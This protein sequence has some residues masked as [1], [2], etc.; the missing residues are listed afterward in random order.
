MRKLFRKLWNDERGN[1]LIIAG[2]ALPLVIGSAGLASDTVQWTLWKRQLQR[3]ADSAA[4][5]GVYAKVQ[6]HSGQ[7]A[8]Q[9]VDADLDDNDHTNIT[10]LGGYP[11]VTYPTG[12]GWL[13]GVKVKLALQKE[14][15]FSSVFMSDPP[16]IIAEATAAT[17]A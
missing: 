13:N 5:A 6:N 12:A 17:I 7:T 2:A 16:V 10:L 4:L 14:L 11:E 3:A 1:A 9:A 15:G 8:A